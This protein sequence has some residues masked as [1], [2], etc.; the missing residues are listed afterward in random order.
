MHISGSQI[1]VHEYFMKQDVAN[2]SPY[3][4][5]PPIQLSSLLLQRSLQGEFFTP[6]VILTQCMA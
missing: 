3:I 1:L 2:Q 6:L 4:T 5:L